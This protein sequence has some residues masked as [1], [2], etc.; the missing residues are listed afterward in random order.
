MRMNSL[1]IWAALAVSTLAAAPA[2][3]Q[4]LPGGAS[5]LNETYTN[6]VLSC[7]A[8]EGAK[9]CAITHSQQDPQSRQRIL[10]MELSKDGAPEGGLRGLLVMPF[11]LKLADGVVLGAPELAPSELAF[12]TCLPAGCIIPLSF[13]AAFVASLAKGGAAEM[14]ATAADGGKEVVFSLPLDGFGA[15][16][17]RLGELSN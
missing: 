15:A 17:A 14:R 5:S 12:S 7:V 10:A 13:D 16:V 3:A 8:P 2:A 9:R 6:W 1:A 4:G 11:G